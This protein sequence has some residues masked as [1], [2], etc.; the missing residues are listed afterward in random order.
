M[1]TV[2]LAGAAASALAAGAPAFAQQA[3]ASSD[4]GV[5]RLDEVVVTA[6]RIEERLQDAP[7]SVQAF[8]AE[9]IEA[10]GAVNLRDLVRATPSLIIDSRTNSADFRP[11]VRGVSSYF[12]DPYRNRAI[13]GFFIDGAP[14][15]ANLTELPLGDVERVEII[16][17]PQSA[18]FGRATYAGAINVVPKTPTDEGAG[19]L[20][21]MAG[22][23]ETWK[24]AGSYA[25]PTGLSDTLTFRIGASAYNYGG[26]HRN[27]YSGR[28]YGA[29]RNYSGNLG[30]R[31][32]PDERFDLKF[33]YLFTRDENAPGAYGQFPF[34]YKQCLTRAAVPPLAAGRTVGV[35]DE[36]GWVCG[37]L[38]AK[39]LRINIR[40]DAFGADGPGFDQDTHIVTLGGALQMD[41]FEIVSN[42]AWNKQEYDQRSNQ[43]RVINSIF[44]S[45]AAPTGSQ[46]RDTGLFESYF[47]ELRANSTGSGPFKWMVGVSG[48]E[49]TFDTARLQGA[50]ALGFPDSDRAANLSFFASLAY[51][52]FD[53][54]TFTIEGRQQTDDIFRADSR[55]VGAGQT[56]DVA[57]VSF[58]RFLP[59]ATAEFQLTDTIGL[60]ASYSEG[61]RPGAT[62]LASDNG[63]IVREERTKNTEAGVRAEWLDGTLRTNVTLFSI[64]WIDIFAETA[65]EAVFGD[66][67]TLR[68]FRINQ[69]DA[70]IKGLEAQVAWRPIRPLTLEANYAYTDAAFKAGFNTR[71][72]F[73]LLG[74]ASRQFLIG[75]R[76][77]YV[78]E[79]SGTF[80]AMWEDDLANGW[81]YRLR[82]D[83]NY[84]GDRFGTELNTDSFGAS[85]IVNLSAVLNIADWSIEGWG[86]NVTDDDTILSSGRFLNLDATPGVRL[87]GARSQNFIAEG[88][89]PRGPAYGV[90][91]KYRF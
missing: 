22:S 35:Y 89:L 55:Q 16:R 53:R 7:V 25:G 84:T 23:H 26:E 63:Q 79:H 43:S 45:P 29:E 4:T 9:D 20:E 83:V 80:S 39:D 6:R 86:K 88:T 17:G 49:E 1:R 72:A 31:W 75:K 8:T 42:F 81:S 27:R 13:V 51:T 61:A 46:A 36:I 67:T 30:L 38:E 65:R 14:V 87:P 24:F 73:D 57:D 12:F 58:E 77:R 34:R 71:E 5:A 68:V 47:L 78:P 15:I 52:F 64:E 32:A 2:F 3:T 48:Y 19:Q 11:A 40:D 90:T 10:R 82:G 62:A 50:Q 91:V 18:L 21:A 70:E 76:P 37:K 59:R 85:T 28:M 41:Q 56:L 33:N 74:Q 66:P 69:G 44:D 54:L 60:Y